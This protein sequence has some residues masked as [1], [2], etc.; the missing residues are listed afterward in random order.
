MVRIGLVAGNV[1][2]GIL[3]KRALYVWAAAIVLMLLRSGPAIFFSEQNQ[4]FAAFLRANAI[5]GALDSWAMLALAA[6]I[7]LGA[8]S[9]G[10]EMTNKTIS[11]VLARP[12]GR[13]SFW[14]GTGSG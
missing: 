6:A 2:R 1:F 10:G 7:F 11:T 3:S 12:I 9:V 4:P 8:A 5:S 13:G 14:S